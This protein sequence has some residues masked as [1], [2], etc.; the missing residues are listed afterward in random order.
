VVTVVVGA[1][2]VLV[3]VEVEVVVDIGVVVVLVMVGAVV[4]ACVDV[5]AHATSNPRATAMMLVRAVR[6]IGPGHVL[7]DRVRGHTYCP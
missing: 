3:V 6:L 7:A 5:R 4:A 2:V 1:A